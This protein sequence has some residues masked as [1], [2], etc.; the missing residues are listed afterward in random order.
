[1]K[2]NV[3]Y[4][5][6]LSL[7][8]FSLAGC[9]SLAN[10]DDVYLLKSQMNED[11]AQVQTELQRLQEQV[12]ELSQNLDFVQKDTTNQ[13]LNL[14]TEVADQVTLLENRISQD[15]EA[16]SQKM[17]LLLNEMSR[18][19]QQQ[20]IQTE[21]TKTRVS[22]PVIP[23]NAQTY[24]IRTGDTLSKIARKF[25]ISKENLLIINEIED[26]NYLAIGDVLIIPEE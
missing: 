24:T 3:P 7:I 23:E 19:E 14:S 1:M 5:I 12:Q 6:S 17:A 15:Q 11:M 20:L 18:V 10:K 13:I 21:S 22:R 9:T 8:T 2:K 25:G 4:F 16:S 26:E